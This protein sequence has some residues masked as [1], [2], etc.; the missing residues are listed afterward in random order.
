MFS[1]ASWGNLPD[2]VSSARGHLV[3]LSVGE[4]VCPLSWIFNK[5]RR[6]VCST[7]SAKTLALNDALDDAMYLRHL[8]SE[9]YH[10]SVRESKIS[11]LAYIN[12]KSSDESLRSTKQVQEKRL[13]TDIAE[14]QCMLESRD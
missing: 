10:D 14:I 6:N 11:I 4:N 12:N 2:K 9:I 7:L 3:F 13:T 1:D 8:I 5:V